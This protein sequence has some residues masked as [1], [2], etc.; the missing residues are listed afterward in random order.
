MEKSTLLTQPR[1]SERKKGGELTWNEWE[2]TKG[3]GALL[4]LPVPLCLFEKR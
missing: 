4:P 2:F 3:L 1:G